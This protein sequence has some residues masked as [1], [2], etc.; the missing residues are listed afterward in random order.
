MGFLSDFY[1]QMINKLG[2]GQ[3][4]FSM[5]EQNLGQQEQREVIRGKLA[6]DIAKIERALLMN[7]QQYA[8]VSSSNDFF[9]DDLPFDELEFIIKNNLSSKQYIKN[10]KDC[11]LDLD[12]LS[13][14]KSA[15]ETKRLHKDELSQK[16]LNLIHKQ[17]A[18]VM[19]LKSVEENDPVTWL[20]KEPA[21]FVQATLLEADRQENSFDEI[22]FEKEL[23]SLGFD[24]KEYL[25]RSLSAPSKSAIRQA[26]EAFN[27]YALKQKKLINRWTR[28]AVKAKGEYKNECEYQKMRAEKDLA[29]GVDARKS[30]LLDAFRSGEIDA[31]Y[32]N[33]RLEQLS[34][35]DYSHT[36][37]LFEADALKNR[38]AYLKAHDLQDLKKDEA[39]NIISLAKTKAEKD[40]KLFYAKSF[41][42][43]KS[44]ASKKRYSITEMKTEKK[45][46]YRG[47][48]AG[49]EMY[50]EVMVETEGD[51]VQITVDIDEITGGKTIDFP[52]KN[53]K[54]QIDPLQRKVDKK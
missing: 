51:P 19:L 3:A 31:Y 18:Q 1:H 42:K 44:L 6:E 21:S 36:P 53:P 29:R 7:P 10:V 8:T 23:S 49:M 39:D 43:K 20:V 26:D 24:Y 22:Q 14:G 46:I 35:E 30:A 16:V 27:K 15:E 52:N 38:S 48:S 9:D 13:E 41:L 45:M 47:Y 2:M 34:V 28:N 11:V 33:Q 54:L 40:K 37:E 12:S 32:Y 50:E 5:R 25:N 17:S 4:P